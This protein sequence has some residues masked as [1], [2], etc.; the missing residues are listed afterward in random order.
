MWKRMSKIKQHLEKQMVITGKEHESTGWKRYIYFEYEGNQYE[1][2]LFMMSLL[3]TIHIGECL[4]TTPDWVVEWDER[5]SRGYE[6]YTLSR[7]TNLGG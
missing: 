1:L 4:I 5:G 2:T 7:R 3:D 6:L